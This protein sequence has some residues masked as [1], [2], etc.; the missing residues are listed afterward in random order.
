[1]SVKLSAWVWDG[2][3]ASG[4]KGIKLL[5]MARL[6]DFSSDEGICWPSVETISRQTGGGRST[7]ITAISQLERDGWL[8]RTERRKGQR[9]ATNIYTLNIKKL[10]EAAKR[11]DG[12]DS[13]RSKSEGSNPERSENNEKPGSHGSESEHDPSLKPDPSLNPTHNA[14]VG[15]VVR[16]VPEYPEQPGVLFPASQLMG[17]FQM[18][19]GWAPSDDFEKRA[20]LWGFPMPEGMNRSNWQPV[21]NNF[22]TYWQAEG[23]VFHHVQWEQKLARQLHTMKTKKP[24]G[25]NHAGLEPKSTANAAVQRMQAVRAQQLR[26]RGESVEVLAGHGRNIFEPLGEQKRIGTV[27]PMDCSDW[28]FDQRPDDERL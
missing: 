16:F 22:I 18:H 2:C 10:R 27:G 19:P 8:T 25:N 4:V 23:K 20:A 14:R 15:E 7:V 9:N 3:A 11:F 26:A 17:K 28:E 6:A 21:I 24:R 13:E 1:M 12:S 5:V